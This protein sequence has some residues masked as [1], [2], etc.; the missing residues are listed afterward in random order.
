MPNRFEI[1][2]HEPRTYDLLISREDYQGN[3]T[4]TLAAIRD[5]HDL[6]I[7]DIGA[8]TGRLSSILV[9]M[10]RSL[11]LTDSSKPM[12]TVAEEKLVKLGFTNFRTHICDFIEIPAEDASLDA[13]VEGWALCSAAL[14]S[15]SWEGILR[16]SLKEMERVLR[17]NGTI[18][19]FETLGTG[20][21]HP[22]PPNER[23]AALYDSLRQ[24]HGFEQTSIRT[25]YAFTSL[26]EKE[27]LLSF[28]FDQEMLDAGVKNESLIYPEC[29]GVWWRHL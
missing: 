19:L 23:F 15:D 3:I 1:Y 10:A 16:D 25:D 22:V 29:T 18:V 24:D 8:G 2:R 17:K 4:K 20:Q 5:F 28:F 26:E 27:R 12:L 13:V 6:D 9:S 14:R 7:A 21:E 11:V